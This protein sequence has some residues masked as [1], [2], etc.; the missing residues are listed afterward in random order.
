MKSVKWRG[1]REQEVGG[2]IVWEGLAS[3]ERGATG[4]V[5]S[6]AIVTCR[7]RPGAARRA[8]VMG[9]EEATMRLA[10]A[11]GGAEG[12][13]TGSGNDGEG[14]SIAYHVQLQLMRPETG[15]CS[16]V[17]TVRILLVFFYSECV[18]C[19]S[20]GSAEDVVSQ[21]NCLI[22]SSALWRRA[23]DYNTYTQFHIL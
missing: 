23:C 14:H 12:R 21:G 19:P 1:Y 2:V 6:M 20:R 22:A 9:L 4:S 5:N 18:L 10:L 11:G 15:V 16:R 7:L 3:P 13:N 17:H 8:W